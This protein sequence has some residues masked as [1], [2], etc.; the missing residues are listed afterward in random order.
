MVDLIC[1]TLGISLAGLARELRITRSAINDWKSKGI[2]IPAVHCKYLE[3]RLKQKSSSI[4]CMDMRPNDWQTWWPE[5]AHKEQTD[6]EKA[7]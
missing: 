4:N 7:A 2:D 3:G 5:L 1:S 6:S